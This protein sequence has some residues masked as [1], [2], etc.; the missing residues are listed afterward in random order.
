MGDRQESSALGLAYVVGSPPLADSTTRSIKIDP[1]QTLDSMS[2]SVGGPLAP[3]Y[4]PFEVKSLRLRNRFALA[5][6]TRE[7]SPDGVPTTEN[8]AHYRA[9]AEG[10]V[11]LLITEG[12]Y[13]G[14]EASGHKRTVPHFTEDAADGWRQ[15]VAAAHSE[16]AAI[17]P[18]LWHVGA[19]RGTASP[20][21]AGVPPQSPSGI[22]L[23]GQPLA[24]PM[25]TLE[26]EGVIARFV[27]AAA[28]AQQ[29]G[30]DGIELHGAHGYL[31]DEFIWERTNKRS[32]RY[33]DR[34]AMPVEVVKAVR[35]AVGEDFAIVFRFSQW[36]ADRY[37]ERIATTPT[38]LENILLP[39]A[40]A[41]V[42]VFHASTRRHWLPE[43]PREDSTLSLAGWTKRITGKAVITVGS[44]G[45]N[46]EFRGA[47]AAAEK[48]PV[49][50]RE[51]LQERI[52]YL[53][54]QFEAGEYD[55]VALGR[56]LIADP[57]W[58]QKMRAGDFAQII[59]FDRKQH[60]LSGA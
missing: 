1:Q 48:I 35:S 29:I 43:F 33:G 17:V 30:F 31:L 37:N 57:L 56:A 25:T 42:D 6:M 32:G 51:S 5:P 28:L 11:A 60:S 18:Q 26:I 47:G 10:G 27:D 8:A 52:V 36:K 53:A 15:V 39:L 22:D 3:L 7:M 23:D 45:V 40:D 12:T 14:G 19:L 38:E 34:M 50:I 58:V 21:N 55:V 41:G 59:P 49:V 54:E 46:T 44:V 4:R 13:I 24:D 16:G 20:L 2:S 9:R